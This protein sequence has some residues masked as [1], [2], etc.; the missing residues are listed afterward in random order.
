M[1]SKQ[2][3]LFCQNSKYILVVFLF[4]F[5]PQVFCA[6]YHKILVDGDLGDWSSGEK[7]VNDSSDGEFLNRI[8]ALF[9]TWDG[10]NLYLGI[11]HKVDGNGLLLYLDKNYGSSEGYDDLTQIDTWNKKAKFI[12]G[13]FMPDFQYG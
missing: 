2:K 8:D 11:N 7:I 9:V 13:G 5:V 12:E 4:L 10:E 3:S 6:P 1:K